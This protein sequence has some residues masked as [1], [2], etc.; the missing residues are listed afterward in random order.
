[1]IRYFICKPALFR[2]AWDLFIPPPYS[3][4]ELKAWHRPQVECLAA[5]EP[6]V[7]AFETIPS[8]KEAEALV[9]LL[10]EF[11]NTKAWLSLSCKVTSAAEQDSR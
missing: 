2:T 11:P 10:R 9:E 5:A 4:Q 7:L 6:D 8:V 1:M 3:S